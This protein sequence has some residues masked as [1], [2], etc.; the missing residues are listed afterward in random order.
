[1]CILVKIANYLLLYS[2]MNSS[3]YRTMQLRKEWPWDF[4]FC[5]FFTLAW[6]GNKRIQD[7]F[8]LFVFFS[9]KSYASLFRQLVFKLISIRLT[10]SYD[11]CFGKR[12]VL[13][14]NLCNKNKHFGSDII[15]STR[16]LFYEARHGLVISS[17]TKPKSCNYFKEHT[18]W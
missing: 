13:R 15:K 16:F 4:K 14:R 18:Y 5:T 9:Y 2:W 17:S 1:M 11:F 3:N 12:K 7:S 10:L 8:Q 6:Y